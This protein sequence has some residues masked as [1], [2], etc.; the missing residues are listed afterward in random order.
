MMSQRIN[1]RPTQPPDDFNHTKKA[2]GDAS[3]TTTASSSTAN[4]LENTQACIRLGSKVVVDHY[5]S[6]KNSPR[7]P[8]SPRAAAKLNEKYAP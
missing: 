1:K 6:P 2:R 5:S 8:D 3:T 7:A 4:I